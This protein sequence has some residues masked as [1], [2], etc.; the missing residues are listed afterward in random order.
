MNGTFQNSFDFCKSF[1]STKELHGKYFWNG[2][3]D[4][5][6]IEPSPSGNF[7]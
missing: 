6:A 2:L 5:T 3:I 4:L 7:I 1:P